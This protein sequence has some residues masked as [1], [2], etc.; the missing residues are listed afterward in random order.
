MHLC[1]WVKDPRL[2]LVD[3]HGLRELVRDGGFAGVHEPVRPHLHPL[4]RL[5]LHVLPVLAVHAQGLLRGLVLLIH[6][7]L[8]LCHAVKQLGQVAGH[9]EGREGNH[10]HSVQGRNLRTKGTLLVASGFDYGA[11]SRG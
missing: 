9:L 1:W 3:D 11:A 5:I 8:Q 6:L 4:A 7:E 2:L 10:G